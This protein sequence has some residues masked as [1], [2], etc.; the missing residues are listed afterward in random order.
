MKTLLTV[1]ITACLLSS[2]S[3][4]YKAALIPA[5][6][7]AGVIESEI[8]K[9]KFH[10]LR[11]GNQ[12]FTMKNISFSTDKK[13]LQCMLES[14][15]YEHQVHFTNGRKSKMKYVNDTNVGGPA[16]LNE[17]H[18]YANGSGPVTEGPYTLMLNEVQKTEILE[19]D[20]IR[21]RKAY[22]LGLSIGIPVTCL[23]AAGIV[24]T[25]VATNL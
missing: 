25:I 16:V 20:P 22:S 4:Y 17:V 21:T 7:T 2:C 15:P 1:L 18:V 13:T 23:L 8:T 19:P 14:L 10:I 24:V 6:V 9:G 3:H 11:K 12:A 5:P